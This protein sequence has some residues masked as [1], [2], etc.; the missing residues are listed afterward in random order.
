M[1]AEFIAAPPVLNL[2]IPGPGFADDLVAG[3]LE[4]GTA[5]VVGADDLVVGHP[6]TVVVQR[7]SFG[8]RLTSL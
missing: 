8:C 1:L 7:V 5:R 4:F 2:V 3:C 6:S